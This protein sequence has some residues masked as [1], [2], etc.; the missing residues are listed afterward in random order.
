MYGSTSDLTFE[1]YQHLFISF[2]TIC[3][4]QDDID[5]ENYHI[6]FLYWR[7]FCL[8]FIA[9]KQNDHFV[10]TD[11]C[12]ITSSN[13]AS[14]I[15]LVQNLSLQ[16]HW[17]QCNHYQWKIL[18]HYH[19]RSKKKTCFIYCDKISVYVKRHPRADKNTQMTSTQELVRIHTMCGY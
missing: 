8:I 10:S 18:P 17:K 15:C 2:Q 6:V 9:F 4:S 7:K 11:L 13:I 1:S 14:Q 19:L 5:I 16:Q 3:I 12:L